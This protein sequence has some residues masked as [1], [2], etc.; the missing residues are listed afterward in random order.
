ME[1]AAVARAFDRWI[2]RAPDGRYCLQNDV[3][4]AYVEIE[5]APVHIRAIRVID[6]EVHLDLS[7]D[8][9]EELAF[10]TLRQDREGRLYCDVRGGTLTAQFS[11]H[12]ATELAP[13]LQEGCPIELVIGAKRVPII[14]VD[15]PVR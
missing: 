15:E 3:N 9:T 2:A 13:W 11:S 1:N 14:V 8:R 7:D 10:E 6:D 4:W 5:G 12:A